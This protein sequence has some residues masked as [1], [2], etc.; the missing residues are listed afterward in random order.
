M[1]GCAGQ[2]V[3]G[4][5]LAEPTSVIAVV[6][7]GGEQFTRVA[8]RAVWV[9]SRSLGAGWKGLPTGC[10]ARW[11]LV[12]RS[13]LPSR[14]SIGVLGVVHSWRKR[15]RRWH[16]SRVFGG[17][18]DRGHRRDLDRLVRQ[19]DVHT[20]SAR[21]GFLVCLSRGGFRHRAPSSTLLVVL[22]SGSVAVA[23]TAGLIGLVPGLRLDLGDDRG[24][25]A[26]L[27]EQHRPTASAVGTFLALGFGVAVVG[28]LG[29]LG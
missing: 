27:G 10:V 11:N 19:L 2:G 15:C 14:R 22:G 8:N 17:R 9:R 3:E 29:R 6:E 12:R 25:H 4:L 20:C 21:A 1:P 28:V 13:G 7:E 24:R 18:L 23:T 16:G 26:S 5:L